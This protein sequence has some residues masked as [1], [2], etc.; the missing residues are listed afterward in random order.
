M[1]AVV[2]PTGTPNPDWAIDVQLS[3]IFSFQVG[4]GEK[5]KLRA[6]PKP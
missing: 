6:P 3:P 2:R 5:V 4:P 1:R